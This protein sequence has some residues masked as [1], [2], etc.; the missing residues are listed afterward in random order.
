MKAQ[1]K[2]NLLYTGIGFLIGTAGIAA[3]TS[4]TAKKGYVHAMAQ[5]MKCKKGYQDMV[6]SA[7]AEYDDIV[8]Q[9]TYISV[10]DEEIEAAKAEVEAALEA[11]TKKAAE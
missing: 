8:A 3:I 9:A 5:G 11:K 4:E 10:S 1:T 2:N 6:E 7:K